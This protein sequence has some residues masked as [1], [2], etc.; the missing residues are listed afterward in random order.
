MMPYRRQRYHKKDIQ[1]IKLSLMQ[2][3][4]YILFNTLHGYNTIYGVVTQNK[5][6]TAD[7]RAIDGFIYGMGLNLHY[8]YT[9]VNL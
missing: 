2:V 1:F 8:T 3:A 9:G 4:G 6:K 7:R 5:M